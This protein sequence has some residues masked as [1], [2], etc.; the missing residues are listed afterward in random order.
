MMALETL[1]DSRSALGT[2][3]VRAPSG[4]RR[5]LERTNV[6]ANWIELR[7]KVRVIVGQVGPSVRL[8][9]LGHNIQVEASSF[10][11]AWTEFIRIA[12]HRSDYH[13]LTF[14]VGPPREDEL[15]DALDAPED[16]SWAATDDGK[17]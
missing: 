8:T 7:T 1:T 6:G 2:D 13:W 5:P 14:N 4:V 16:E 3:I 11:N 10:A 12:S 17:P 9:A 15:R